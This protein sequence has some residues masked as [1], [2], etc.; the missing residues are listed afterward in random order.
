MER[1]DGG[2]YPIRDDPSHI[3]GGFL[4]FF[5]G[6]I[7]SGSAMGDAGR[8]TRVNV[9]G[10]GIEADD[11]GMYPVLSAAGR[12]VVFASDATNLYFYKYVLTR[13]E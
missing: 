8:T 3:R 13:I 10:S 2:R 7:A 4:L 5:L 6:A 12:Y 1:A 11:I 9:G